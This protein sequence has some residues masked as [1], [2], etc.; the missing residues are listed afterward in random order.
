[1]R[2]S[3]LRIILIKNNEIN[4]MK[5]LHNIMKNKFLLLKNKSSIHVSKISQ[6]VNICVI[7]EQVNH[8]LRK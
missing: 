3:L 1:M 6:E 7:M 2:D 5:T 8:D 4:I